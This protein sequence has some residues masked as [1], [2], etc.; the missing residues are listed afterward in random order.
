MPDRIK[1]SDRST[2]IQQSFDRAAGGLGLRLEPAPGSGEVRHIGKAYGFRVVTDVDTVDSPPPI[3]EADDAAITAVIT[4]AA[5]L[6]PDQVLSRW[7]DYYNDPAEVVGRN[8]L[9]QMNE[10]EIRKWEK[11]AKLAQML[12]EYP[13]FSPRQVRI[14]DLRIV[15]VDDVRAAVT[16]HVEEQFQNGKAGAGNASALL[17]RLDAGWRI[18]V[19]TSHEMIAQVE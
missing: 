15:Y 5:S 17:A 3:G 18:L 10:R 19:F 4:G 11:S 2:E 6:T 7:R 9:A 12:Q 16:Y 1:D 14:T 8:F 13:P